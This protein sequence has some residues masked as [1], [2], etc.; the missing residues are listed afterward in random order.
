M[1]T[2]DDILNG[3]RNVPDAISSAPINTNTLSQP[4]TL[5]FISTD[6]A[7]A[8]ASL[9]PVAPTT[10]APGAPYSAMYAFG[11]SLTDTGT[12]SNRPSSG[13]STVL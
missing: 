8:T 2:L 4:S 7:A 9:A 10:A 3:I 5:S 11:D 6:V 13:R 12:R 1:A